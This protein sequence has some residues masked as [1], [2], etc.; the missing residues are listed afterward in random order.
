MKPR[1]KRKLRDTKVGQW[2]IQN[3]PE[4]IDIVA[5]S[6][7]FG[8]G[9]Q[10]L[11][12]FVRNS[13]TIPPEQRLEFERLLLEEERIAQDAVTARW[14]ADMAS[15]SWLA[16]NVRPIM[17]IATFLLFLIILIWDSVSER[18]SVADSY[19]TICESL[20]LVAFGA[21]FAG[22]TVEKGVKSWRRG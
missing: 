16:K 9:L 3:A 6:L 18:F 12:K 7:P 19:L 10:A 4:V 8:E 11:I 21:Y 20:L 17:L 2:A 5:D 13:T 1:N 22:R 14:Q 15:E